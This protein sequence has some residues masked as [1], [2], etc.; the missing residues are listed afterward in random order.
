MPIVIF[1]SN[2]SFLLGSGCFHNSPILPLPCVWLCFSCNH[3]GFWLFEL[4][5]LYWNEWLL[6]SQMHLNYSLPWIS[7]ASEA[8][9]QFSSICLTFLWYLLSWSTTFQAQFYFCSAVTVHIVFQWDCLV[10]K[11]PKDMVLVR[12]IQMHKKPWENV[13][14]SLWKTPNAV[15]LPWRFWYLLL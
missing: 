5:L 6:L 3:T 13:C 15:V 10:Q 8:S 14:L 12:K 11:E 2:Y 1:F 7:Q 9:S 4:N